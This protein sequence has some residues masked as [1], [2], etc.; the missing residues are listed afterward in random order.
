LE[1]VSPSTK[2]SDG[3]VGSLP[4]NPRLMKSTPR[5][6]LDTSAYLQRIG[7]QGATALDLKTLR[8][9]HQTH[10]LRVPFENLSI[11]W[12]EE[13]SLEPENLFDKIVTRQRG[14]FCYELNGL[15]ALLLEALGFKVSRLSAGVKNSKGLFSPDFDHLALRVE[16]GGGQW[17]VDVGFGDSFQYPLR[18][19][20]S[21]VQPESY[22]EYRL[23]A[24]EAY[25]ILLKKG[26]DANWE[27]Q[28]R[29]RGEAYRLEDFT[30]GC[31]FHAT[32]VESP[33]THKTI[34][35]R[36]T[37]TGRITLSEMRLIETNGSRRTERE[38]SGEAEFMAVL[39]DRFGI[40]QNGKKRPV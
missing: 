13:I 32:S 37:S 19:E 31:H 36:L 25:T 14:G 4:K 5:F 35:S 29:F 18:L 23:E 24:E 15:F 6:A 40:Y 17:L 11:H 33:F 12:H 39:Q 26:I 30:A 27:A 34:C 20:S 10:L 16:V 2:L 3:S 38:L 21:V 7:Y 1:D 9:L 22:R 8:N 28:Y